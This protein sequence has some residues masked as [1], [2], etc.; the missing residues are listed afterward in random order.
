[1]EGTRKILGEIT[2][3]SSQV[4]SSLDTFHSHKP[5]ESETPK[6]SN[7]L[8]REDSP[9]R[10]TSILAP[11]LVGESPKRLEKKRKTKVEIRQSC[12]K[13]IQLTKQSI[14]LDPTRKST[15]ES[16]VVKSYAVNTNEGLVRNYNEDRV[17]I[18]LNIMQ[19]G[20]DNHNPWPRSAFFGVYDGHCGSLC[21]EFLRDHLH[22]FILRDKAFPKNPKLALMNGFDRAEKEFRKQCVSEEHRLIER[23]GSCALVCLVVENKCYIANVGDSRAVLSSQGGLE[24]ISLS[25]DHKPE[26]KEEKERILQNGGKI[27]RTQIQ[28]T[29]LDF[30][31]GEEIE[32]E[33][34]VN[35]PY[36]VFPGRL[37][38]CRTIGD[39]EAKIE[40]LG[41]NPSVIIPTPEVT[42]FMIH[43]EHDFIIL[44]CDGVFDRFTTSQL[45]DH[46][47]S[48]PSMSEGRKAKNKHQIAANL[49]DSVLEETFQRKAWDNI[50]VVMI[51]FQ[52]LFKQ[53]NQLNNGIL[54]KSDNNFI[55]NNLDQ[56]KDE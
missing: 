16:G 47:W 8:E 53:I 46:V 32:K 41:G 10:R 20:K 11:K 55:V 4:S 15:Q 14:Q 24:A 18:I 33:E 1:M 7:Q 21:A 45:V 25:K 17:S 19:S 44:G 9:L 34:I 40:S 26:E 48:S 22:K 13:D 28:T 54:I 6:N 56:R 5:K 51:C 3:N 43:S 39:F 42:E 30:D 31:N 37:S 49:V 12:E 36:R 35:G 52:N 2:L 27:Y 29:S 23:S 38:V 50:T